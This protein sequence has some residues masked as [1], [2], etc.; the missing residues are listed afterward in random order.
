MSNI[1][2][3]CP[4]TPPAKIKITCPDCGKTGIVSCD[5][6]QCSCGSIFTREESEWEEVQE[7]KSIGGD[8]TMELAERLSK[9]GTSFF[10]VVGK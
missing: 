8:T 1:T 4:A 3:I 9:A 5:Y 6:I 7:A 2:I 10:D